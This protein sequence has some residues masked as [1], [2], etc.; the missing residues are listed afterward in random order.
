MTSWTSSRKRRPRTFT[1][2][3]VPVPRKLSSPW[4]YSFRMRIGWLV[5]NLATAFA[6]AAVVAAFSG[7]IEKLPILAVF[8]P[9]IAGMGGNASA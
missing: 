1:A 4:F 3:S 8:M 9:I 2:C 5:V 6:A 7:T